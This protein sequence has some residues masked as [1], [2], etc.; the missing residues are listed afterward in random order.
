MENPATPEDEKIDVEKFDIENDAPH[1][2]AAE[3]VLR[4]YAE[5]AN[6]KDVK[7]QEAAMLQVMEF[8]AQV[9]TEPSPWLIAMTQANECEAAFDWIGAEAAYRRAITAEDKPMLAARGHAKLSSLFHLLGR[10]ELAKAA[11]LAATEA[12]R[13]EP[14]APV[15]WQHLLKGARYHM[16]DKD[17]ERASLAL[18]EAFSFIEEKPGDNLMW[19]HTLITRADLNFQQGKDADSIENDMARAWEILEPYD[20]TYFTAGWQSGLSSWWGLTARLRESKDDWHG[21]VLARQEEVYRERIIESLPQLSGPY[22][23]NALAVS[24]RDLARALR[25]S[26][27]EGAEEAFAESCELR[28]SIGLEALPE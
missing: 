17:Y 18:D 20:E 2:D 19:A 3:E 26:G 7:A 10:K 25:E 28:R 14:M 22:A 5:A 4:A 27:E 8:M 24:L 12:A 11:A 6:S 23:R 9:E 1:G 16:Q 15:M 13:L 21:V